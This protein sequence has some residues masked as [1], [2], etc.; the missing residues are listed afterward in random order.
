MSG[1]GT[2][3]DG[4]IYSGFLNMIGHGAAGRSRDAHDVA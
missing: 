1:E 2:L 3:L 4:K